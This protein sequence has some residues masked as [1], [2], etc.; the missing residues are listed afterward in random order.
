MSTKPLPF[1]ADVQP[2]HV[3]LHRPDGGIEFTCTGC[4]YNVLS[5]IPN[6][7]FAVC[8]SCRFFG[9]RPHIVKAWP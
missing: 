2:R 4:G 9:E 3:I 5:A 1:S 8:L 7:G 6:D